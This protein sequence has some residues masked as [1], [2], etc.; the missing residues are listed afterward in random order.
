MSSRYFVWLGLLG[1]ALAAAVSAAAATTLLSCVP[2]NEISA[3]AAV[4]TEETVADSC[5]AEGGLAPALVRTP[6]ITRC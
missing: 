4:T 3:A 2:L 5:A 6:E 1:V